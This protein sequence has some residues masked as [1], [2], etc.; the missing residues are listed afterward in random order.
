MAGAA[1]LDSS[2]DFFITSTFVVRT[3]CL[4][5]GQMPHGHNAE[6][7][8]ARRVDWDSLRVNTRSAAGEEPGLFSLVFV[9]I[10]LLLP[11][12][13]LPPS[14][15]PCLLPCKFPPSNARPLCQSFSFFL[16][17][18]SRRL[19]PHPAPA[20]C[21]DL[22]ATITLPIRNYSHLIPL[23]YMPSPPRSAALFN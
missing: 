5:C 19:P 1:V 17:R 21:A 3:S 8:K 14:S 10:F 9:V 20:A 6:L 15:Q 7:P 16:P 12:S 18:E 11:S 2:L 13:F 22:G 4:C 23:Y